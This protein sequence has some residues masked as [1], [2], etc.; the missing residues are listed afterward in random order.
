[1]LL[2]WLDD[3]RPWVFVA[4]QLLPPFS[5]DLFLWYL[6]VFHKN[7][8]VKAMKNTAGNPLIVPHPK[9]DRAFGDIHISTV[10]QC[11]NQI[12]ELSEAT[13]PQE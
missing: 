5:A 10:P 9:V 6:S 3:F 7:T 1:M 11:R 4:L 13:D 12:I 2:V 8:K